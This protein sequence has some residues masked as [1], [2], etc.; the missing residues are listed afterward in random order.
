MVKGVATIWFRGGGTHLGEGATPNFSP[1]S[2]NHKGPPL[3]TFGYPR[4]PPTSTGEVFQYS[5]TPLVQQYW[6][7]PLSTGETPLVFGKHLS[8]GEPLGYWG[9]S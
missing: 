8:T 9:A 2:S 5:E 6:E 7:K 1:Q 4:I 3:C